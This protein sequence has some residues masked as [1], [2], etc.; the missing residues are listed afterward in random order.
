MTSNPSKKPVAFHQLLL[1]AWLA[2]WPWRWRQYVPPKR[3]SVF[4]LHGVTTQNTVLIIVTAMR[5][6]NPTQINY[7]FCYQL[8]NQNSILLSLKNA[9]H[10]VAFSYQALY[11]PKPKWPAKWLRETNPPVLLH[12]FIVLL[13]CSTEWNLSPLLLWDKIFTS[14]LILTLKRLWKLPL[15]WVK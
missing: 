9:G 3:Q 14:L 6:S 13:V 4:E 2:L 11:I 12:V 15:R 10:N 7:E 5:T 8:Q 1:L